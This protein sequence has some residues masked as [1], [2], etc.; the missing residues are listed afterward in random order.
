MFEVLKQVQHDGDI[1][2]P[3]LVIL[4]LFQDLMSAVPTVLGTETSSA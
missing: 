4:N 3:E 2:H 1:H